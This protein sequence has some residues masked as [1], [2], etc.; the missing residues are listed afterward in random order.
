MTTTEPIRS[1][2]TPEPTP[3]REGR[4]K[5][6]AK[7]ARL[8]VLD[9]C[10][11]LAAMM[12]VS[13]HF[14]A[15]GSPAWKQQPSVIFRTAHVPAEYG[16]LGVELF[17]VISGFVICMSAWGRSLGQF[18][19]SRVVRLYPAYWLAIVATTAVLTLWPTQ[20]IARRTLADTAVNFTMLQTGVGIGGVD[21]VYW[22]LW[23]E[24]IFYTLF[25]V[26]VW[27]GLTYR[28]TVVF[29]LGWII[30]STLAAATGS[31]AIK[32]V[33]TPDTAPF[34]IGGIA[35][36]LIRRYGSNLIVWG[37]V[38]GSFFLGLRPVMDTTASEADL[39]GHQVPQWGTFVVLS[40]IYLL[41]ASVAVGWLDWISWRGLTVAG[42]LTYPL[43]LL[44]EFIGWTMLNR[45]Q[46]ISPWEAVGLTL[47]VL[48]VASYLTH[49]LV[50]R[51]LSKRLKPA[52]TRALAQIK[53]NGLTA[54]NTPD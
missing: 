28:R 42:A 47:G 22:S 20:D 51:P 12:V 21:A 54:W 17:F 5:S 34:F 4:R 14:L 33:F 1:R 30:A 29:C 18:A 37:I 48:L 50:E 8:A 46:Q 52:L 16:W 43:Y 24:L 31:A 27:R 11:F 19:I 6:S 39:V 10:R 36:Y 45:L 13:Y 38:A 26:T 49:R 44:H 2:A 15:I 7:P 9:G 23:Y 3:R 41:M 32:A 35:F 53:A 25:A 40:L